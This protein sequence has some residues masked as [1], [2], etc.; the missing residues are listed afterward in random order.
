MSSHRT[1]R[2]SIYGVPERRK[3]F[4][5]RY[6]IVVR[7]EFADNYNQWYYSNKDIV[8]AEFDSLYTAPFLVD[9]DSAWDGEAFPNMRLISHEIRYIQGKETPVIDF[10]YQTL[11][12]VFVQERDDVISF[13]ENGLRRVERVL[14]ARINTPYDKE[15][16]V[17]SIQHLT[18]NYPEQTLYLARAEV[19]DQPGF[20]KV[21]ETWLKAG[22]L[23]ESTTRGQVKGTTVQTIVSFKDKVIP[24][25]AVIEDSESEVEGIPTF[26]VSA[27]IGTIEGIKSTWTEPVQ[28]RTPGT[29]TLVLETVNAGGM[30]GTIPI[31]VHI[32]PRTKTVNATVTLE[33]SD[34]PPTELDQAFNIENISCS[35]T[36]T[37]A[38]YSFLGTDRFQTASGNLKFSGQKHSGSVSASRVDYPETY[39]VGG[40]S[41]TG[42]YSFVGGWENTS[43]SPNTL[44]TVPR[45]T[46]ITLKI[47]ADG[48][49]E[50]TGY[51]ETG[52]IQRRVRPIFTL[53]DGAEYYEII[54]WTA[55]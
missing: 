13:T 22:V 53:L 14:I 16:G 6:E 26:T 21:T 36:S 49:T 9:G 43:S 30:I 42:G 38:R 37:Q 18:E 34:T 1:Q 48:A 44:V 8:D 20:R 3:L 7:C 4:G 52:I 31:P 47:R 46:I 17:S 41:L 11:T 12:D 25:G 29:L 5:D 54:T 15:V 50:P 28:A 2:L 10:T 51:T 39:I 27:I 19:D 35:V 33:I 32:P 24:A 40:T 45:E 55:L 23:R